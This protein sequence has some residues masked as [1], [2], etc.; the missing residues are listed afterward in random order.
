MNDGID[1]ELSEF[2]KDE[3]V[4]T[5][6]DTSTEVAPEAEKPEETTEEVTTTI[7]TDDKEKVEEGSTSEPE[8]KETGTV[9]IAALLDEREKRQTFEKQVEEL[10]GKLNT[11]PENPL[12]DV[13]ENQ[14]GFVKELQSKM[15]AETQSVRIEMSQD[16]MRTMH[17]DYDAMEEKFMAL[18]K[19]NPSLVGKMAAS[20]LPA[21]FVYETAKN[22]EKLA[23]MENVEEWEAK[24][25]AELKEKIKAEMEAEA[26]AKADK[27]AETTNALT[28]SLAAQRAA[29]GNG[30]AK[31]AD[32][33]DPLET[34]FNR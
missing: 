29:G 27:D 9:P 33:P 32:V 8:A 1:S 10:T 2:L 31:P 5:L 17:V 21:K 7:S 4:E 6:T 11:K 28:P 25:T 26:K 19:D 22:A 18:A 12:P 30:D 20:P 16:F 24:K 23:D 14:E 34:T 15:K 3:P 13:L